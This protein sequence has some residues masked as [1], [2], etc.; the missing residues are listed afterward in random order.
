[1]KNKPY[2]FRKIIAAIID[3]A[4]IYG[5]TFL[6]L[7]K[8]GKL[9]GDGGYQANGLYAFPPIILWVV[10]LPIAESVFSR[11]LGHWIVGLKIADESGI[12]ADFIQ[13]FKRRLADIVEI[14]F[15]GIPAIIAI[16][17]T[18]KNQRIGD[19]W[20]ETIVVS[21]KDEKVKIENTSG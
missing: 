8:F 3:Y 4:I 2:I 11:T 16:N 1:M 21:R 10:M 9:T 12:K 18:T 6:Y 19:L 15:F 7:M 5:I 20:A 13:T 17:K 14:P